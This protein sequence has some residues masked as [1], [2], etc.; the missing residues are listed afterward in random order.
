MCGAEPQIGLD[1]LREDAEH[2]PIKEV[3]GVD[4]QQHREHEPAGGRSAERRR[5]HR[6]DPQRPSPRRRQGSRGDDEMPAFADL[7]EGGMVRIWTTAYRTRTEE[8]R[9]GQEG[10]GTCRAR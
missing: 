7:T 6:Y 5:T 2:L 8:R 9:G 10:V 1:R 3:E 4:D